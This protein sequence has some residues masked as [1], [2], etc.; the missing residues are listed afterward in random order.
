MTD[1]LTRFNRHTFCVTAELRAGNL[2]KS[3]ENYFIK[4]QKMA[5]L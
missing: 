1:D 3:I 5:S 4:P 2:V